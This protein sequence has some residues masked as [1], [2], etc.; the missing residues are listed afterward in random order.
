M[1]PRACWTDLFLSET[2]L[3]PLR[4]VITRPNS[5]EH[6]PHPRDLRDGKE[7]EQPSNPWL[8]FRWRP[9]L[10]GF[11]SAEVCRAQCPTLAPEMLMLNHQGIP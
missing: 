1:G 7:Q 9:H 5:R 10:I 11:G 8:Q 4:S 3:P 6:C 2:T